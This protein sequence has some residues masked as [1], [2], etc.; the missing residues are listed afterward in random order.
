M[1]PGAPTT[2]CG[3]IGI[4]CLVVSLLAGPGGARAGED[5]LGK[6]RPLPGNTSL[7]SPG[8]APVDPRAA[9]AAGEVLPPLGQA[10]AA[11]PDPKLQ[12]TPAPPAAG[13][14][15]LPR[16]TRKP[17]DSPANAGAQPAPAP[18]ASRHLPNAP[19]AGACPG[20]L[21]PIDLPYA[22]HLVNAANPT[23]ALAQARVAEA[24]AVLKQA[25][26]LW[27][28][29]LWLGGNPRSLTTLPAFYHHDG[30]I[31]N[32]DG[33]VF[34]TDKNNFFV[35]AGAGIDMSFA[36]ALFAPRIGRA[37]LAAV[38][39]RAQAVTNDVQLDVALAY[40]DLLRAYGALAIN[41]E[42]IRNSEVMYRAA[43]SA[44]RNGLG[45]TGADPNR[46]RTELEVR[47]QDRLLLQGQAATA[48]AR[49][50]QL[51]LL[52]PC[53]DLLPGD[54]TVVPIALVNTDCCC[55]DLVA[56]ALMNRPELAE[57][58]ALIAAALARWKQAKCRPLLPTLQAVYYGG[59][60][61]G[62]NPQLRTA[63]GREDVMAQVVWELR[64]GGL[65]DLYRAREMKAQY[66]QANFRLFE[67]QARV[68]AEVAVALKTARFR[69]QA[70]QSA[71]E[72]VR[73]AEEMWRKLQ[74][75]AFGVGLPAR[76]Y[77]PLEPLLAERALLEARNLYLD[78]VIEYNRAQFRLYWAMGQPPECSLPGAKARPLSVPV[79]P[80]PSATANAADK[81]DKGKP[82]AQEK[83]PAPNDVKDREPDLRL[84]RRP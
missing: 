26:V 1:K 73:N 77:D 61:I 20:Q 33:R 58:R 22:L 48:S 74:K 36:D 13:P 39:A 23:I 59:N 28:P 51:L 32:S 75:I 47:R 4:A 65:G 67:T 84:P 9:Y 3:R 30:F 78:E 83:K 81:S 6:P 21:L 12:P 16:P 40:L 64:N 66:N 18:G 72:G 37:G 46:A 55:D 63:G 76:Q 17:A 38:Q 71:Q 31:Q 25:Q 79:M 27:I 54:Q 2:G 41:A 7:P 80:D 69:A 62:G 52:D 34:F 14:P 24:Y 5:L 57:D 45:K 60:F 11:P 82:G 42:A 70:L 35:Q 53:A 44:F 8:A 19:A 50:A 68:A 43:E 29:N 49:L 10:I 56:A 15:D